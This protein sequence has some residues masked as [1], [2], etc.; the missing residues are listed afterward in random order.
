[1]ISKLIPP[2]YRI[3]AAI[4]GAV[5]IFGAG[6]KVNGWRLGEEM[7]QREKEIALAAIE[8]YKLT[9]EKENKSAEV[10]IDIGTAHAEKEVEVKVVER[11]VTKEVI[12]YV[13]APYAGHLNMPLGWVRLDSAS[14]TGRMPGDI[15]PA[16]GPD[17]APSGFTDA[18]AIAVIADRNNICRAEIRKLESLQSWVRQQYELMRDKA[19]LREWVK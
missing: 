12:K 19:A 15:L 5:L 10:T 7:E 16:A 11:V 2:Q 6:W 3:A 1:M 13:Q 14:A 4:G 17:D 9:R 18:D 8:G